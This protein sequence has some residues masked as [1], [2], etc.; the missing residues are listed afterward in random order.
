[1]RLWFKWNPN[2]ATCLQSITQKKCS[3]LTFKKSGINMSSKKLDRKI[4]MINK[5]KANKYEIQS[6]STQLKRRRVNSL[7]VRSLCARSLLKWQ[8]HGCRISCYLIRK[9]WMVF[10]MWKMKI[11]LIIL[12]NYNNHKSLLLTHL[13]CGNLW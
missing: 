8:Q 11:L 1:M 5:K 2:F 12:S 9:L 13:Y 3:N 7:N 10:L 6:L 4:L